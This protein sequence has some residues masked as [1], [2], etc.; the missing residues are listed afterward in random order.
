MSETTHTKV[1]FPQPTET[2]C[3]T[4]S[5][6]VQIELVSLELYQKQARA[7]CTGMAS[8]VSSAKYDRELYSKQ[9]GRHV[10]VRGAKSADAPS[11]V[12]LARLQPCRL[13][14]IIEHASIPISHAVH[15]VRN[16]MRLGHTIIDEHT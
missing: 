12:W 5:K 7:H 16:M 1:A 10:N 15:T 11:A 6:Q 9:E 4:K 3:H 13:H 14:V 8:I 2:K